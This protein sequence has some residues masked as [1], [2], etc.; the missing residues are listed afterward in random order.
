M[1]VKKQKAFIGNDRI[2]SYLDNVLSKGRLH[3]ASLFVGPSGV[4]KMTLAR[5]V[6][7]SLLC[8]RS[9]GLQTCGSC[10]N[11]RVGTNNHPDVT[12]IERESE[13]KLIDVDRVRVLRERLSVSPWAAKWKVGMID[14]A[15][16]LSPGAANALLKT[17]EEPPD[18]SIIM[19]CAER[20][21]DVPA[22]IRSRAQI[23]RFRP[24]PTKILE[25]CRPQN[26]ALP[27]SYAFHRPGRLLAANKNDFEKAQSNVR[28]LLTLLSDSRNYR[29]LDQWFS[30]AS[31]STIEEKTRQLRDLFQ[32]LF[33]DAWLANKHAGGRITGD[34]LMEKGTRTPLESISEHLLVKGLLA[35]RDIP[36][37]VKENTH[38]RLLFE[39]LI[40]NI[41]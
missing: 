16:L 9:Q 17:L 12:I 33:R 18:H 32:I 38:P 1:L 20:E 6:S 5:R 39:S 10:E 21:C 40:T 31:K 30:S 14:G 29:F 22:T 7:A 23:L 35:L 28:E 19:L 36:K 3:H 8:E 41:P 15:D 13:K 24:V 26:T 2:V 4:G 27:V 34:V 11:C 37:R 25:A